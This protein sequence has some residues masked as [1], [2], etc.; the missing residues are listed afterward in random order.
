M[1]CVSPYRCFLAVSLAFAAT[2]SAQTVTLT[3]LPPPDGYAVAGVANM[4]ADGTVVGS[5]YPSGEVVRWQPG[6]APEVLGGDT[7]TLDNVMPFISKDGATIV[8]SSYFDDY[9]VSAPGFWRGGTDWERAS[10]MDPGLVY[11]VRPLL[12]RRGLGRRRKQPAAA[13]GIRV[14]SAVGLDGAEWP[15]SLLDLLPGTVSGQAWA[16][17]DDGGVAAGFIEASQGDRHAL[18]RALGRH[19]PRPGSPMP[20]AITS[21]RRWPA[22]ST[23]RSS[24]APAST[25]QPPGTRA[26]SLA[27]DEAIRASNISARPEERTGCDL[28]RVRIE[29]GRFGHRRQLFHRSTPCS[30]RSI[31]ASCGRGR[32][33]CRTWLGW[34]AAHGIHYGEDFRIWSSTRSPRMATSC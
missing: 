5:V 1:P 13:G 31:A 22:T 9:S 14:D 32:A 4:A 34:L 6:Q 23:A 11:A 19:E 7:Y 25:V 27:L 15:T 8:A 28:L 24:S 3:E 16:V 26:P 21:A 30:V 2:A 12:E 33:A 17:A 29:L 10:G 18:W 20:M